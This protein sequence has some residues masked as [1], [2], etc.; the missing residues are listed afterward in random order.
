L[1][2][3]PEK[4]LFRNGNVDDVDARNMCAVVNKIVKRVAIGEITWRMAK[5]SWMGEVQGTGADHLAVGKTK[6]LERVDNPSPSRRVYQLDRGVARS[7]LPY[8]N[9][10]SR[11]VG[12]GKKFI[13]E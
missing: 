9:W 1:R 4:T 11:G 8:R 12:S 3:R 13:A 2:R 5:L 6:V 10:E 7:T